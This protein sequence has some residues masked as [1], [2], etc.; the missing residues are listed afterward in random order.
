MVFQVRNER[1]IAFLENNLEEAKDDVYTMAVVNYA[2]HLANSNKKTVTAAHMQS[3][4][5][6][7]KGVLESYQLTFDQS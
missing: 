1:A 5:I 7:D 2:L 3:M 6:D 4:K